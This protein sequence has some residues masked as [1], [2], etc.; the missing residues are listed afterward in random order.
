M[1]SPAV[2]PSRVWAL[3]LAEPSR[4]STLAA[5]SCELSAACSS[6]VQPSLSVASTAAPASTSSLH[7]SA[8]PLVTLDPA[9]LDRGEE[10]WRDA[11]ADVEF[12]RDV[13]G[14]YA[15]VVLE[16]GNRGARIGIEGVEEDENGHWIVPE[17][18]TWARPVDADGN[19]GNRARTPGDLL[20]VGDVIHVRAITSE[21]DGSFVRWSLRQI[22]HLS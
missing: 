1:R 6:A 11:L 20:E 15:A 18:V 3:K 2:L 7:A 4:M 13:E 5:P 16:I 12:P 14:W 10:V 21:S 8:A 9:D 17:D 19:V 22:S